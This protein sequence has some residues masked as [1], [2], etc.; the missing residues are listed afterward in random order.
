MRRPLLAA[1]SHTYFTTLAHLCW[2]APEQVQREWEP[3][4]AI[5]AGAKDC[6]SAVATNAAEAVHNAVLG[7]AIRAEAKDCSWAPTT[8][9]E[10]NCD[11]YGYHEMNSRLETLAA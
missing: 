2:D 8:A 11:S 1:L 10:T 3:E 7:A 5:R 6:S 9:V 4:A